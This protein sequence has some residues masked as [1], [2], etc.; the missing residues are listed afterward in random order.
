MTFVPQ[1]FIGGTFMYISTLAR[2]KCSRPASLD[3]I[4]STSV[5][6]SSPEFANQN[7]FII[8]CREASS[9]MR[10]NKVGTCTSI[11]N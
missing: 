9:Y 10:E 2:M 5:L 6:C 7:A 11:K 8:H 1:K 4:P 3:M